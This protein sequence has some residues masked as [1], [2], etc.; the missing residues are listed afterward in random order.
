MHPLSIS[1]YLPAGTL[2]F[3]VLALSS[4]NKSYRIT[5]CVMR[6]PT[7]QDT[8][9]VTVN[10]SKRS[11]PAHTTLASLLKCLCIDPRRVACELNQEI[12]RRA[13]LDHTVLRA[14]DQ[15]EVVQM[16]GGG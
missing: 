11:I 13:D 15:V 5:L 16:I 6:D 14:G 9:E 8:L 1:T 12:V 7:F 2:I 3:W 4:P 10:G